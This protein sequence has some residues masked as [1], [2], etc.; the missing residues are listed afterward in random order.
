[1]RTFDHFDYF[2][3]KTFQEKYEHYFQ[4]NLT[5]FCTRKSFR[6]SL[7]ISSSK[8]SESRVISEK[9]FVAVHAL[10]EQLKSRIRQC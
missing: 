9:L 3:A 7:Y 6:N 5:S 10:I 1:M 8:E 4:Q 2:I